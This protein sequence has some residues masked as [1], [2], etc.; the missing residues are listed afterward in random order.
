MVINDKDLGSIRLVEN[1]RARKIIVRYKDGSLQLTHPSGISISFIK[2]T[3]EDMKPRLLNLL[4]RKP[5]STILSPST[6]FKTF[7]FSLKLIESQSANNYYLS[8]KNNVLS[9]SCPPN[10]D[11]EDAAVQKTLRALVE[12][13]FR[14]E[15]NRLFSQKVKTLAATFGF[16]YSLVKVNKS[17]S[18]WGS[19]SSQKSINLSLYCMLLP[20]YLVDFIILHE[21]CHTVEMNHGE[22]FW[23]L[24]D[25]VSEGKAKQ[26]TA[27][28]KR[29]KTNW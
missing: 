1:K 17:H 8:L 15:A 11:Y 20:E 19:C 14:Y 10:T 18:R 26:Y 23:Q 7:S 27:E 25:K 6:D 4:Q 24:L 3:I 9:I 2:K 12:K 22:H 5:E 16:S 29:Y 28:L 13:A 21:L